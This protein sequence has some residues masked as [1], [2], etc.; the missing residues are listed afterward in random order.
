M[1]LLDLVIANV[2][3]AELQRTTHILQNLFQ[4]FAD[5]LKPPVEPAVELPRL[6]RLQCPTSRKRR[7]FWCG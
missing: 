4:P 1:W 6:L 2:L 3:H 5:I 7:T